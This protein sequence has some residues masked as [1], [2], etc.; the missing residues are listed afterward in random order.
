MELHS[1]EYMNHNGSWVYTKLRGSRAAAVKEANMIACM[2]GL[3]TRVTIGDTGKVAHEAAPMHT[4]Q[5]AL[6]CLCKRLKSTPIDQVSQLLDAQAEQGQE[7]DDAVEAKF[8]K[9]MHDALLKL[10]AGLGRAAELEDYQTGGEV[11]R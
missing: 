6:A 9:S 7:C 11:E 2:S 1:I 5:G 3:Q 10:L 4:L 8:M